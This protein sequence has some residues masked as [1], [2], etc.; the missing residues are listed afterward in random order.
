MIGKHAPAKQ[1]VHVQNGE[2]KHGG[3]RDILKN[4]LEGKYNYY[5]YS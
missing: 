5:I 4:V 3:G 1:S 2:Y